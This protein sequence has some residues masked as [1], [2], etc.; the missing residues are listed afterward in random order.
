M[1]IIHPQEP[2]KKPEH[3]HNKQCLSGER[4]PLPPPVVVAL[5]FK[6][7]FVI[8]QNLIKLGGDYIPLGDYPLP[9]LYYPDS[10]NYG[11]NQSLVILICSLLILNYVRL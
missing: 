5:F 4:V 6:G 7:A 11:L 9:F 10:G 3:N 1:R 8:L 2:I